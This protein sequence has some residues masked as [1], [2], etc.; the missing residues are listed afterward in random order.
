VEAQAERLFWPESRI[1]TLS[2]FIIKL[3]EN[4]KLALMSNANHGIL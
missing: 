1:V 2:L 3:A 4:D